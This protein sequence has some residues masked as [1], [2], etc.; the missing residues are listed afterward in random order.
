MAVKSGKPSKWLLKN[1]SGYPDFLF[2][3]LT[4]SMILLFLVTIFWIGF[5]ILSFKYAGTAKEMALLKVMDS[6]KT[7]LVSLVGV[8]FS[9]AG[10]YTVRRYKRDQHTVELQ[11][12][13]NITENSLPEQRTPTG[14]LQ[15]VE[16]KEDI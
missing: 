7:G 15:L 4:Y 6:L 1:S 12:A 2:T 8:I 14:A 16:D 9:L 11:N 10:S 5:G 13:K 3:I